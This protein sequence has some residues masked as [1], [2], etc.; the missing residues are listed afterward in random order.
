MELAPRRQDAKIQMV[1]IPKGVIKQAGPGVSY[2]FATWR[3]CAR[4]EFRS[5]EF[6]LK[7]AGKTLFRPRLSCWPGADWSFGR[8]G[9][10]LP[11][12]VMSSRA[13]S[14]SK[15]LVLEVFPAGNRTIFAAALIGHPHLDITEGL[16]VVTRPLM[17][18]DT[19]THVTRHDHSC[20]QTRPLM[21]PDTTTHVTRQGY[22][23]HQTRLL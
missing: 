1:Q 10:V 22:S 6:G 13:V 12:S 7:A 15:R 17:S 19:T 5:S 3:L 14:G 11:G 16:N 9:M 21:S 8:R 2:P 23:C 18:P 20:H 4:T